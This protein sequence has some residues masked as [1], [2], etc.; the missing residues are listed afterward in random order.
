MMYK[1]KIYEF[2]V[3]LDKHDFYRIYYFSYKNC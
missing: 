3:M 1:I 2:S